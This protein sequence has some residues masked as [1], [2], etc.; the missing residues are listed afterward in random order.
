MKGEKAIRPWRVSGV[1][2]GFSQSLCSLKRLVGVWGLTKEDIFYT[3]IFYR[4]ISEMKI[5]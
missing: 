4:N 3:N 5:G 2:G 1:R